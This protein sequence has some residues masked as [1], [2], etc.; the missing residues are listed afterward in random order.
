M[1]E[2]ARIRPVGERPTTEVVGYVEAMTDSSAL[3]W[4]WRPG[5]TDRLTVEL[6]LGEQTLASALA[7]GMR[8]DLARSGI[9]DGGHAF[10]L[11][12][13][14]ELRAGSG[15]LRVV[16]IG[17]DGTTVMLDAPPA[18]AA[19]ADGLATVQRGLDMLLGSQRV[20]HRNLQ[21][22]LLQQPSVSNALSEIATVQA[23]LQESL[24]TFELFAVR[25]EHA[26]ASREAPTTTNARPSRVVVIIAAIATLALFGS[27]WA[28]LRTIAG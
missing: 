17:E 21:A 1:S 8:A 6:R 23:G 16:V 13:P 27:C 3:G 15:E 28:L 2:P 11:P 24:A 10:A 19:N 4:A 26:L 25:L 7:N 20:M 12:I 22:A 18:P 5:S 9:G 14:G